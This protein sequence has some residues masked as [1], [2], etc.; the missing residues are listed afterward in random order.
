M[1]GDEYE[2]LIP[3]SEKAFV[4]AHKKRQ[5]FLE[6]EKYSSYSESEWEDHFMDEKR[7]GRVPGECLD[8]T[9]AYPLSKKADESDFMSSKLPGVLKYIQD[10]L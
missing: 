8:F 1:P 5:I 3:L 7:P 2:K 4:K 10:Q 6:S 9:I